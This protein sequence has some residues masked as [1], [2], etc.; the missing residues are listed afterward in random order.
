MSQE[1]PALLLSDPSNP[2]LLQHQ[3]KD[4][5]TSHLEIIGTEFS[6]KER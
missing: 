5:Y 3:V 2:N 1:H 4:S 6:A